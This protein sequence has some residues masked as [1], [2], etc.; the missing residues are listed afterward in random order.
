MPRVRTLR[1]LRLLLPRDP[2][3]RYESDPRARF[4][5]SDRK[6]EFEM[7]ASRLVYPVS[8]DAGR[9]SRAAITASRWFPTLACAVSS[10]AARRPDAPGNC[11]FI[12]SPI[13]SYLRSLASENPNL[14]RTPI[15]HPEVWLLGL[16]RARESSSFTNASHGTRARKE[17]EMSFYEGGRRREGES[18]RRRET[19]VYEEGNRAEAP[20]EE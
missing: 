16:R 12:T 7:R 3:P 15:G 18:V 4:S 14:P 20:A 13:H 8:P 9:S 17:I 2:Y 1:P 19:A 11:S 5:A 6:D 10:S